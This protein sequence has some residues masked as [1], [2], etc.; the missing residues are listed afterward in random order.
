MVRN[1]YGGVT[2]VAFMRSSRKS[3]SAWLRNVLARGNLCRAGQSC[4]RTR[5]MKARKLMAKNLSVF[6][7]KQIKR[8]EVKFHFISVNDNA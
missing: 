4:L 5:I 6:E 8:Q 3:K 7:S 2:E 1:R